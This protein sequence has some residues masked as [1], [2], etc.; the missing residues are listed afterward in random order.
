M[1]SYIFWDITL[2]SPLKASRRK[3]FLLG[4]FFD[5]EEGEDMSSETSLTF[6][7]IHGVISQKIELFKTHAVYK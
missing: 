3:G 1:K 6:N 4:L 2:C 5:P 7:G